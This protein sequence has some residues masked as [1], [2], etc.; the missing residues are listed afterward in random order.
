M[1][2][3]NHIALFLYLIIFSIFSLSK[4]QAQAEYKVVCM[5]FYNLENLFDTLDTPG[6]I[7]EEFLPTG[8]NKYTGEVYKDK[9]KN[10]SRVIS[11]IGTDLTPDG[12]AILGVSEI[13]CR[14]VLEDLA[15]MPSLKNRNYQ[16][17]HEES[18]DARGVD[19]A[20]L[21]NPKYFKEISH[22]VLPVNFLE[23]GNRIYHSRDIL[24]V[25]GILGGVDT[26]HVFVN[27]WPSRRGGTSSIPKRNHAAQQCKNVV[28]SLT[29][30]NPNVKIL[31][32]GDLNDD[33]VNESVKNV[34]RAKRKTKEVASGGLYN[35]MWDKYVKG[36]GTLTWN[37]AWNLFDQ[38]IVSYGFLD[39]KQ[40]G[41]FF[42]TAEVF[43]RS[44]LL[45]KEG[46]FK[47]SPARAYS[48]G[49]YVGGYSDHLPVYAVFLQ[50]K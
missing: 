42:H 33:P 21:Y 10:L 18:P 50:K 36:D 12:V 23:E 20:L 38:T 34:L 32:T 30:A 3:R 8:S 25:T 37:A 6:K 22:K 1:S 31:I 39:K 13:E 15:A 49:T 7:D 26:L 2:M 45:N 9:L 4:T 47:G 16:I 19:V 41:Y 35:P 29:A 44:Y 46:R 24:W 17:V 48:F 14:S 27:H 43:R 5:G 40:S 11:E 28:D